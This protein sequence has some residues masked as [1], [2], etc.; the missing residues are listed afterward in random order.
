MLINY[1]VKKACQ[2]KRNGSNVT[3]RALFL[4]LQFIAAANYSSRLPCSN[5]LWQL[6]I[7]KFRDII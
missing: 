3:H 2:R 1:L 7:N 5:S 6:D 4:N